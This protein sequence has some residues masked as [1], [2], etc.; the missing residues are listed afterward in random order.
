M[1][2]LAM[3]VATVAGW[4]GDGPNGKPVGGTII[5]R[6]EADDVETAYVE[7]RDQLHGLITLNRPDML[8]F[9][10]PMPF[11]GGSKFANIMATAQTVRKLMGLVAITGELA[12][13]MGLDVAEESVST[14]RKHFC[15]DGRA[16]KPDV[17]RR[18][19]LLGWSYKDNNHADALALW[20][21]AKAMSDPTW[22]PN[23]TPLFGR[24]AA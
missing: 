13:R 18:C 22:A 15:G 19:D 4:A 11:A 5:A 12:K 2:V 23:S 21:Y 16:K 14:V 6:S 10:S 24:S 3:D 7:Y 8:I 9:E 1:R 17:Q 20:A